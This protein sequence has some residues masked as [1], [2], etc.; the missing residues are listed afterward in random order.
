MVNNFVAIDVETA[1][2]DFASI[3]QIGIVSFVDGKPALIWKS[4]INP[5]DYF[6]SINI[7]IHGITESMCKDAPTFSNIIHI[8]DDVFNNNIVVAHT[9]FDRIAIAKALYKCGKPEIPCRWLDS[10]KVVRRAWSQFSC[11]GYG[12]ENCCKEFG[13]EYKAHDAAEDARAAGEIVCL[14]IQQT[15]TPIEEW[16]VCAYMPEPNINEEESGN[17][18]F[19]RPDDGVKLEGDPNGLL[20]GEELVFTGTLSI[21]RAKAAQ[22]AAAAGCRVTAG[23][24]RETDFLV[25]GDKDI[26]TIRA[27]NKRSS[28]HQKVLD[29]IKKGYKVRILRESDFYELVESSIVKIN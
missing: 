14:A 8:L 5:Q 24:T 29:M 17:R 7:Q 11:K 10:S 27:G 19:F 12:L 6:D 25:I 15:G 4:L 9:K 28:K 22:L 3:C 1:N 13:I 20:Y 26:R 2:A 23:V 21:P 16:I 18:F